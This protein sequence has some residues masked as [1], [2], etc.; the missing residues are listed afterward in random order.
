MKRQR[1]EGVAYNEAPGIKR[2]LTRPEDVLDLLPYLLLSKPG[3]KL[4][5]AYV[6]QIRLSYFLA[7]CN[8][9]VG[10]F[11]DRR[12]GHARYEKQ[13]ERALMLEKQKQT[14]V[15]RPYVLAQMLIDSGEI[16]L[17]GAQP[18]TVR[19]RLVRAYRQQK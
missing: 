17:N 11:Q 5:R 8:Q 2:R 10:A 16:E 4:E 19:K 9:R 15:I 6:D 1:Q 7:L 14:G 18:I 12:Q 13:K 3:S